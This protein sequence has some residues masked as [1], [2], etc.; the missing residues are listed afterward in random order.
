MMVKRT[1]K[2]S[3]SIV[4]AK[5]WLAR[6]VLD[7]KVSGSII[8]QA[9]ED[10]FVFPVEK[11]F[12]ILPVIE[13]VPWMSIFDPLRKSVEMPYVIK[14]DKIHH[15]IDC[16]R[17]IVVVSVPCVSWV[18]SEFSIELNTTSNTGFLLNG[19]RMACRAELM[20]SEVQRVP[21]RKK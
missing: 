12:R 6:L 7:K 21:Q 17:N 9:E 11:L 2:F 5:G 4:E 18:Y 19:V 16:G 14:G 3:G 10:V 1:Y 13:N 20:S 15:E 8:I